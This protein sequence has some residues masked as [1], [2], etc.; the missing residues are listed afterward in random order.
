[1]SKNTTMKRVINSENVDGL[2]ENIGKQSSDCIHTQKRI[3]AD[4]L[5]SSIKAH[6]YMNFEKALQK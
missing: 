6:F 1:M 5:S 2:D 4:D 3:K